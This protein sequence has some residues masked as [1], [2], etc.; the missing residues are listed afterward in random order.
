MKVSIRFNEEELLIHNWIKDFLG[1]RG[2]H[3][4]DSQVIKIS[5]RIA[6]N[7]LRNTFGDQLKDILKREARDR[8][9]ELRAIQREK[10]KKSRTLKPKI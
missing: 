10:I 8:L 5:Q 9:L 4:E 3:G 6:F 2:L 7:V 1:F